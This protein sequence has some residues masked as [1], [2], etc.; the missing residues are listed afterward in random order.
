MKRQSK[1]R[2]VR[3][4][5]DDEVVGAPRRKQM[6]VVR[7]CALITSP[8]LFIRTSK[9]KEVIEDSDEEMA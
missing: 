5:D 7:I 3:D 2:V 1:K 6:W 4:E 8:N 9:S